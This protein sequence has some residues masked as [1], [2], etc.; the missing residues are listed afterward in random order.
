MLEYLRE[1]YYGEN[2]NLREMQKCISNFRKDLFEKRITARLNTHPEIKRFNRLAEKEFGF[3]GFCLHIDPAQTVNAYTFPLYYNFN[4]FNPDK[5]LMSNLVVTNKGY[6]FKKE[7]EYVCYVCVYR[8]IMN[9]RRLSDREVMAIILHEIGHNFQAAISDVQSGLSGTSLILYL[10]NTIYRILCTGDIELLFASCFSVPFTLIGGIQKFLKGYDEILYNYFPNYY[11]ITDVIE[12]IV[13][14]LRYPVDRI[15]RAINMMLRLPTL[16]IKLMI[17]LNPLSLIL[18]YSTGDFRGEKMAD[19]FPTMYG[20]GPDLASAVTK[21]EINKDMD[22]VRIPLVSPVIGIIENT[23]RLLITIPDEHPAVIT[24]INDQLEY[25]EKELNSEDFD[26]KFKKEVKDS[27]KNIQEQLD[28]ITSTH[29]KGA[30]SDY[31]YSNHL[32]QL[33]LYKLFGGDPMDLAYK[34]GGDDIHRDVQNV[35]NRKRIRESG[36]ILENALLDLKLK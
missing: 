30:L 1:V 2:A 20:Y 34:W 18:F 8:G 28:F 26:P 36:D 4:Q 24:R 14:I 31:Q 25:L 29:Y 19:N 3:K 16:P 23:Y 33:T 5:N 27:I 17:R 32:Y 11:H 13:G 22:K 35:Y 6:R 15:L 7:A 9:D 10:I 12:T 21:I